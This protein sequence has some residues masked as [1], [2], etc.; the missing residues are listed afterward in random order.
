MLAEAGGDVSEIM[1]FL[2]HKTASVSQH[3][4][5]EAHRKKQATS[6]IRKL[7]DSEGARGKKGTSRE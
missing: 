2:G 4:A 1:A 6:A 5:K 3:Y 7:E